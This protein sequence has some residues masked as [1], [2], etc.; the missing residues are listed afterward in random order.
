MFV[1]CRGR[2]GHW[3]EI[4]KSWAKIR[5]FYVSKSI[6]RTISSGRGCS[7][8]GR[9]AGRGGARGGR[10]EAKEAAQD[11]DR[12]LK[13]EK[14]QMCAVSVR[15]VVWSPSGTRLRRCSGSSGAALRNFLPIQGIRS[16]CR[17]A[18]DAPCPRSLLVLSGLVVIST[19]LS[20]QQRRC[21][22]VRI[23]LVF[24]SVSV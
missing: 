13:S 4:R 11:R 21:V 10:V 12:S 2:F 8:A 9:R 23:E 3:G 7:R 18:P 22:C 16:R 1:S 14:M 24:M 15:V 19:V 17:G 6:L 5:E 20:R